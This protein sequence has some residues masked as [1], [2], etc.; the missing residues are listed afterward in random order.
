MPY[1]AGDPVRRPPLPSRFFPSKT[2]PLTSGIRSSARRCPLPAP[3]PSRARP[4]PR[5]ARRRR[6][7]RGGTT[8][9][10]SV[11]P[12]VSCCHIRF[13]LQYSPKATSVEPHPS[14]Q[15]EGFSLRVS[16]CRRLQHNGTYLLV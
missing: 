6:P 3:P 7:R 1:I 9:R 11:A 16:T 15:D 13:L 8:A 14:R 10:S 2:L 12:S 5:A 4:P